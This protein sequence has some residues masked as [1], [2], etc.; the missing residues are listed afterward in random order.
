MRQTENIYRVMIDRMQDGL[1]RVEGERFVF[2]NPALADLV[3]FEVAELEG[4]PY[5]AIYAPDSLARIDDFHRRRDAGLD[6]PNRYVCIK[7][8]SREYRS[9]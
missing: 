3:G 9:S 4:Q 2:V 5:R 1:Y 6:V 7:M 8:A